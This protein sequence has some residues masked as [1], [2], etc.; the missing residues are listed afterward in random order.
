M[1][2]EV[3]PIEPHPQASKSAQPRAE[4]Q[5]LLGSVIKGEGK[6]HA[7][8]VNRRLYR[9]GKS[10]GGES[11]RRSAAANVPNGSMLPAGSSVGSSGVG[12]GSDSRASGIQVS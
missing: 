3:A 5:A 2:D 1:I 4:R 6:V 10:S 8:T 12:S 11:A 7:V 9:N